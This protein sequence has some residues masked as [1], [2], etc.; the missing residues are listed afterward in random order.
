M[1]LGLDY[2]VLRPDFYTKQKSL[3]IESNSCCVIL[4]GT[5]SANILE[6]LELENLSSQA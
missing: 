2:I 3:N 4:G 1:M 6:F 5:D